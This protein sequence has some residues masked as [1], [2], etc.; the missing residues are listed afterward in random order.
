MDDFRTKMN[1]SKQ[2]MQL[3]LFMTNGKFA[4]AEK[5]IENNFN[6]KRL[7]RQDQSLVFDKD[8]DEIILSKKPPFMIHGHD[9]SAV[10]ERY[11]MLKPFQ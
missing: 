5:I 10:S 8:L 3:A 9:S 11:M 2:Q 6:I 1:C 4:V 7:S